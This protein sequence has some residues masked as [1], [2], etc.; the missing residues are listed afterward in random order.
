VDVTAL[1]ASE[2]LVYAYY[3]M[4]LRGWRFGCARDHLLNVLVSATSN[5]NVN[6][7]AED[8]DPM[9]DDDEYGDMPLL[10]EVHTSEEDGELEDEL[11]SDEEGELE[12]ELSSDE[13]FDLTSDEESEVAS[14]SA[15]SASDM[16]VTADLVVDDFTS[17]S[18]MRAH[19]WASVAQRRI[20]ADIS[21]YETHGVARSSEGGFMSC[22]QSA[23]SNPL[24][25]SKKA[26]H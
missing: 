14:D 12:D 2:T 25:R 21:N 3:R 26:Q 5:D 23:A 9:E 19:E 10:E 17:V 11:S 22:V 8:E 4:R 13:D 20:L 15:N 16:S 1:L 6:T 18:A 7:H 24:S